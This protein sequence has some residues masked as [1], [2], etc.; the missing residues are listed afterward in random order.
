VEVTDENDKPT[1]S[2]KKRFFPF[3][4]TKILCRQI[5]FKRGQHSRIF[6]VVIKTAVQ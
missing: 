5:P 6:T 3:L 1:I 2:L 4:K